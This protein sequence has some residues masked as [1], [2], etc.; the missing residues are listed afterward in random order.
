[1]TRCWNAEP[2]E[3]PTFVEIYE[4]LHGMLMDNKV[5]RKTFMTYIPGDVIKEVLIVVFQDIL[6]KT[7]HIV[8]E[9]LILII[10]CS[11]SQHDRHI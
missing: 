10:A 9:I 5:N 3:R 4:L 7:D 8:T 6:A 11:V 1:M 2:K